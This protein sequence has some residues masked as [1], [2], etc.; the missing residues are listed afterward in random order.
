MTW[1]SVDPWTAY[2]RTD[3]LA[4]APNAGMS[5]TTMPLRLNHAGGAAVLPASHSRTAERSAAACGDGDAA[6]S[7][8]YNTSGPAGS[9]AVDG[10]STP[11]A[12]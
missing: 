9:A 1:R 10:G 8:T 12:T 5:P 3:R 2:G 4:E 6:A 11:K 7:R